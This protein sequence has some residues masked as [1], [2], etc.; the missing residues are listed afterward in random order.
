MADTIRSAAELLSL[1]DTRKPA[2]GQVLRDTILSLSRLSTRPP[3]AAP[4]LATDGYI[5]AQITTTLSE[6]TY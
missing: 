5:E 6:P 1:I 2:S 4:T 3:P